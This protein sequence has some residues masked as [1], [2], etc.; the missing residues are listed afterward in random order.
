MNTIEIYFMEVTGAQKGTARLF[1]FSYFSVSIILLVQSCWAGGSFCA[2]HHQQL[3]LFLFY[4]FK[5][6][7]LNTLPTLSSSV[8]SALRAWIHPNSPTGELQFALAFSWKKG[9]SQ[10]RLACCCFMQVPALK[11]LSPEGGSA[12]PKLHRT[13]KNT[14]PKQSTVDITQTFLSNYFNPLVSQTIRN[15]DTAPPTVPYN[16]PKW[17]L[18]PIPT[19]QQNTE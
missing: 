3:F 18:K 17:W 8:Y 9:R 2:H 14:G 11:E 6:W 12:K 13:A 5:I 4:Q 19:S 1:V 10:D 15:H 16:Y 7:Y